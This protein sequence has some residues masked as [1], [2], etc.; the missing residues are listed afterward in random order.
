MFQGAPK[1]YL[2]H[3]ISQVNKCLL[4]TIIWIISLNSQIKVIKLS[5]SG[6]ELLA[7]D[8]RRQCAEKLSL[9]INTGFQCS[10]SDSS[11][12]DYLSSDDNDSNNDYTG[13]FI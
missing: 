10:Y 6:I 8:C 7:C 12:S 9:C 3:D 5:L 1:P 13:T 4:Q 11:E 2:L